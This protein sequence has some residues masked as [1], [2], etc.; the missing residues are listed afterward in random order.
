MPEEVPAQPQKTGEETKTIITVL[1]LILMPIVGIIV[2]WF[3]APWSKKAKWIVTAVFLGLIALP[4]LLMTFI[5][6]WTSI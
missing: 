4:I 2:M 1:L 6:I 3:I 5:F